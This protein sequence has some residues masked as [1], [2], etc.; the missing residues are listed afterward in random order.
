M[1]AKT[2][3]VSSGRT[4]TTLLLTSLCNHPHIK[5]NKAHELFCAA[6]DGFKYYFP[7]IKENFGIDYAAIEKETGG[8]LN[9]VELLITSKEDTYKYLDHVLENEDVIKILYGHMEQNP[10]IMQY[11]LD[12]KEIKIIHSYRHN[13]VNTY[14][15]LLRLLKRESAEEDKIVLNLQGSKKFIAHWRDY[16]QRFN[17][18]FNDRML[19]VKYEH[20]ITFWNADM[21]KIQQYME[22]EVVDVPMSLRKTPPSLEE[23]FENPEVLHE[24]Q[25]WL[26]IECGV[27]YLLTEEVDLFDHAQEPFDRFLHHFTDQNVDFL[28]VGSFEGRSTTWCLDNVLTH[29]DSTITCVDVWDYEK[30]VHK[31]IFDNFKFNMDRHIGKATYIQGRSGD[32]LKTFSINNYDFIYIDGSHN[33]ANVLEDAVLAFRLLKPGGIMAFD[34]Y[35]LD[36]HKYT[37][38]T[39][40]RQALDAFVDVF[41]NELRVIY[42][43]WQLW[44]RKI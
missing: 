4:G 40:P 32:V 2:C 24:L 37:N 41:I 1:V 5:N 7:F 22:V 20:L 10:Y 6:A 9:N 34:D 27:G 18:I 26:Q 28:E 14:A 39:I 11:L 38:G 15:S 21:K 35:E 42:R 8:G 13:T 19:L 16:E 29:P 17:E 30:P 12:H 25:Q 33:A 3:I 43:D 31:L 23:P 36:N 44:I